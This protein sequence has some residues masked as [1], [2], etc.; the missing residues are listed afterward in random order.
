MAE[1]DG[2]LP[3]ADG[4]DVGQRPG[5]PLRQEPPARRRRRHVDAMQERALPLAGER[6]RQF[7]IGARRGVDLQR[8]P[9]RGAHRRRERRPRAE[10]RALDIGEHG[11]RR[12]QLGLREG[13]E[14]VERGDAEI[15][16]DPPPRARAIDA[17]ARHPGDGGA[18][19]APETGER[20]IVADRVRTDDLAGSMRAISAASASPS[21]EPSAKRPVEMSTS[22]RPYCQRVSSSRT[23]PTPSRMEARDGSSSASSVMVPAVTSRTTS[24]RTTALEPRL[25]ASAGPPAARRPRRGARPRS[26]AAG[27]RRPGARARRTSGCR[28]PGAGR[29]W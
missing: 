13:A 25:R 22:A 20:R 2:F 21:Q 10:L 17:V 18:G 11:G 26:A 12:D 5:E 7:E 3:A 14:A 6:P 29:A 27:N 8:L 23:R 1:P 28:R 19:L 24:R 4:G 16:L 15:L 9:A